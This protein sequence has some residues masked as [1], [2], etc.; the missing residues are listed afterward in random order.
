[1]VNRHTSALSRRDMLKTTVAG[2]AIP[3]VVPGG[4]L[5]NPNEPGA[6]DRLRIGVIGTGNRVSHLIAA[7]SPVEQM[8]LIAVAD[9]DLRRMESFVRATRGVFPEV[10]HCK[11]YQD[12]REMLDKEKLDGVFVTT[13]TR[14]AGDCR[15]MTPGESPCRYSIPRQHHMFGNSGTLPE[16]S[17]PASREC[18]A[19]TRGSCDSVETRILGTCMCLVRPLTVPYRSNTA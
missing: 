19:G 5:G 13:P 1:M 4:V 10:A 11:R 16:L 6:N 18:T 14:S 2:L 9:C 12:Y 3:A 7:A 15:C 8:R 17:H